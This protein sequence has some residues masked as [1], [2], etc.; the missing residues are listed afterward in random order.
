MVIL[1]IWDVSFFFF[2]LIDILFPLLVPWF[3]VLPSFCVYLRGLLSRHM[4]LYM[5]CHVWPCRFI[6]MC[7]PHSRWFL[8]YGLPGPKTGMVHQS[9]MSDIEA[10][11]EFLFFPLFFLLGLFILHVQPNWWVDWSGFWG[12]AHEWWPRLLNNF[13]TCPSVALLFKLDSV[14]A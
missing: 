5:R 9:C 12:R 14:Q 3:K 13:Q 4:S 1:V 7:M 6:C 8:Q 11:R 10:V 2:Y